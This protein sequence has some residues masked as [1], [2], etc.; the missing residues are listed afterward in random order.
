ME[1]KEPPP[2]KKNPFKIEAKANSYSKDPRKLTCP[3]A[4]LKCTG[5]KFKI[6]SRYY[7]F[8]NC[9]VTP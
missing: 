1:P 4:T 8:D 3:M 2:Q 7:E 9:K 5:L 6:F